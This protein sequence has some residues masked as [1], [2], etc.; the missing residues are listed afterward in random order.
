VGIDALAF[1]PS[2]TLAVGR[3]NGAMDA[4]RMAD[5]MFQLG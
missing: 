4:W 5:G 2:G 1:S 3:E